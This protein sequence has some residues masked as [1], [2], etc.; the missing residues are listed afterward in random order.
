MSTSGTAKSKPESERPSLDIQAVL[1]Y[2]GAELSRISERGWRTIR[3]PFHQDR[4]PSARINLPL[5][6]FWCP[7]CG[8]KGDAIGIVM[9]REGL[10]FRDACDFAERILGASV[11]N[12]PRTDAKP[13]RPKWKSDLFG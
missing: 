1:T 7:V 6:S 2:Y 8:V 13:E 5:N 10:E 12:L 9:E 11:G 3:C 4:H